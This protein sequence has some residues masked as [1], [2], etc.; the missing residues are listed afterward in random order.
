MIVEALVQPF[1]EFSFMRRALAGCIALSF[2]APPIGVFLML[3]RMSLTGDAMSHAILPGVAIGYM[4]AGLSVFAMT[5]GGL[6][7]G[8]AVA[9][10]SGLVSRATVLRED[11]SLAAFYLLSLAT[12]VLLISVNGSSVDLLH[13]LFGTVLAM[14]DAALLLIGGIAT[15]TMVALAVVY[16]PLVLECLDPM[17]LRSVSR[18]STPTHLLFLGLVVLNLVGGFHALGTLLAVGLMLLPAV[19]ARFWVEDLSRMI[20]VAVTAALA[21]SCAGLLLSYHFSLPSGPAIILTSGAIYIGSMLLGPRGSIA[22]RFLPR[23][24]LEA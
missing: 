9:L 1:T 8:L 6:V 22:S 11:A 3:R 13:V 24:H 19:T 2:S 12:G 5:I 7:V 21:A 20:A 4:L 15:A 16:R 10:T 23:T 17:F 14:D 18:T